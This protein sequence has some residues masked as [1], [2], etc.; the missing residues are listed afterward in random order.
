MIGSHADDVFF[1]V[2]IVQVFDEIVGDLVVDDAGVGQKEGVI[3]QLATGH[4]TD[5]LST[6][7]ESYSTG[8]PSLPFS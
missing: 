1:L 5:F 4:G 6:S 7:F 2:S 8:G 3:D